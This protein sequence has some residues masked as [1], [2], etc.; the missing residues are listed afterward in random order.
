MTESH[1]AG[2]LTL[3]YDLK[4]DWPPLAWVARCEQG[5]E[6][7]DVLHGPQLE[8]RAGWF[9]E[10]IWDGAF[11]EGAFHQTGIVFGSG[12]RCEKGNTTFVSSCAPVDRLQ[13]VAIDGTTYVSNSLV[14]LHAICGLRPSLRHETYD[15]DFRQVVDGKTT[16]TIPTDGPPIKLVYVHNLCWDGREIH[17]VQKPPAGWSFKTF[18]EYRTFLANAVQ[19][20]TENL[21]APD[22]TLPLSMMGTLSSGYDTTAVS[23]L[24]AAQGLP[25]AITITSARGGASD[26]GHVAAKRLGIKLHAKSRGAWRQYAY[27]EIPFLAG[28]A[29]GED[30]FLYSARDQLHG[31]VLFTGHPGGS[32]WGKSKDADRALYARG[33]RSGVSLTEFRLWSGFIHAP[34]PFLG[35]ARKNEIFRISNSTAMQPWDVRSSYSRPIPRRI[36]EEAGVPRESFGQ[37]KKAASVLFNEP[38]LSPWTLL[39]VMSYIDFGRWCWTKAGDRQFSLTRSNLVALW[40][41]QVIFGTMARAGTSFLQALGEAQGWSV[42]IVDRLYRMAGDKEAR[43]LLYPWAMSRAIARYDQTGR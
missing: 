21:A 13:V 9:C 14:A 32:I 40:L 37:S 39:T 7:V 43:K 26:T 12:G 27:P 38:D 18:E 2:E 35:F 20:L 24:L 36:G 23:A 19:Q 29:K 1:P 17:T 16:H 30:I 11:D 8:T 3:N 42:R 6:S 33:D 31:H 15:D 25:E 22:R 10:A 41:R 28:D 34:I 5:N 4:P